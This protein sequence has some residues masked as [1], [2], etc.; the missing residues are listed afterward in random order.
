MIESNQQ[1]MRQVRKDTIHLMGLSLGVNFKLQLEFDRK[2]C[3]IYSWV[4]RQRDLV[5]YGESGMFH[6]LKMYYE[7]Y[8]DL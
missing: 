2:S 6:F 8:R 5:F 4:D 3:R 7:I 1:L